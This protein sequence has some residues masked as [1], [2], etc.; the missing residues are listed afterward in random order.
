MDNVFEVI[1]GCAV[2]GLLVT[3]VIGVASGLKY[4]REIRD[5]LQ[6]SESDRKSNLT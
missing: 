4:L 1:V 6:H 5:L 3:L 2:I